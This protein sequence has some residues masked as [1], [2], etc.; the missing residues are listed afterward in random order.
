MSSDV[1]DVKDLCKCFEGVTALADFSCSLRSGEI[2]GLIGPNG[3]GKTTF[4]NVASGFLTPDA[5]SILL[6]GQDITSASPHHVASLGVSRTFQN[7]RLVRQIS[8]L[9][10]VLL[11]F[12][13]QPGEKLQTS[14][15]E[16]RKL[17]PRMN[18][19]LGF[20]RSRPGGAR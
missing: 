3:A 19:E 18:I 2:L 20:R 15:V 12:P 14:E 6:K 16:L 17:Y 1:L 8:V 7:L 5:G 10:N 4:F 13:N 9:D 11:H